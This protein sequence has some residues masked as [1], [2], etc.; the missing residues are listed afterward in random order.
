[1]FNTHTESQKTCL[2]LNR[3]RTI[4][5]RNKSIWQRFDMLFEPNRSP[6]KFGKLNLVKI[7]NHEYKLEQAINKR[8]I[9]ADKMFLKGK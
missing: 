1:M 6:S 8:D 2:L 5:A 3:K 7:V 4:K 9:K